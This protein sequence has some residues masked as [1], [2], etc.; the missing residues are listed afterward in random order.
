MADQLG[1]QLGNYRLL[2]LLGQGGFADVYLGQ[3]I[4]LDSQAAIKVLQV[5]LVGSALEQFR[6]EGR[7]IASLLHPNI[8]RVFDFG[9]EKDIP[10]LVMDFA[11]NGSLR[12]RYAKGTM[13]SPATILPHLTQVA[14]ALQ[15]AHDRKLI[16]RDVKPENM[17]LGPTN[18]VLLS[19]FGL[20]LQAQSTG[21]QTTREMAGTLPYMAPEQINGKPRPA[22]DQYALG[23]VLYEWLSGDRPFHGSLLEIATQH[24]MTPPAPLYGKVPGMTLALQEVVF[25]ALAKDFQHRFANMEVFATAF[26]QACR[27]APRSSF[28][29]SAQQTLLHPSAS[30]SALPNQ[31]QQPPSIAAF[32]DE[33]QQSTYMHPPVSQPQQSTVIHTPWNTTRPAPLNPP[34]ISSREP[35]RRTPT[36]SKLSPQ[37]ALIPPVSPTRVVGPWSGQ[38]TVQSTDDGAGRSHTLPARLGSNRGKR[39][40]EEPSRNTSKQ[41]RVLAYAL[42]FLAIAMMVSSLATLIP[43]P[44]HESLARLLSLGGPTAPG[45]PSPT[46]SRVTPSATVTPSAGDTA[47]TGF[48]ADEHILAPANVPHLQQGQTISVSTYIAEAPVVA[49]GVIYVISLGRKDLSAFDATTYAS[50]WAASLAPAYITGVTVAHGIL[51]ASANDQ[52]LYALAPNTGALVWTTPVQDPTP[53]AEDKNEVYVTPPVVAQGIVYVG[54]YKYHRLY[55]FNATTGVFLWSTPL[56]YPPRYYYYGPTVANGS[57]YIGSGDGRLYAFNAL[58]GAPLWA[59]PSAGSHI[60]STPAVTDRMVYV[61]TDSKLQAFN[62]TTGASLWVTDTT[63]DVEK[64]AVA[65]G[66]VYANVGPGTTATKLE[67]FNATTGAYLWSSAPIQPIGNIFYFPYLTI[68]NGVVYGTSLDYSVGARRATVN[69]NKVYAFDSANGKLLWTSPPIQSLL[70][71]PALSEGTLYLSVERPGQLYTF[72]LSSTAH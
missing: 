7:T 31:S 58:T 30:N 4:H 32:L 16:H 48:I 23:I 52:K 36:S 67:A 10:F 18:E 64:L 59:V 37:P 14:H 6:D 42:C 28:S 35:T 45:H 57:I 34:V 68:A 20:V 39:I 17:L 13:Q 1:Q 46:V 5:R 69:N 19:D 60:Y 51:Y 25:T 61:I 50:L 54:S 47:N 56:Q 66:R 44:L 3:H 27:T 62:A 9:V 72:S 49:N 26:E 53:T 43:G 11:P 21:S 2:R 29:D 40:R 55:A 63:G 8:V 70:Y 65:Y 24:L 22:S 15:Y 33:S 71:G 41:R 12:Q 38:T